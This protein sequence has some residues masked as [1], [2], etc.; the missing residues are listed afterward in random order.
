MC[1]DKR[2]GIEIDKAYRKLERSKQ[3]VDVG[4]LQASLEYRMAGVDL[5]RIRGV[6]ASSR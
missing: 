4:A 5:D 3:R 1:L 6:L 2:L